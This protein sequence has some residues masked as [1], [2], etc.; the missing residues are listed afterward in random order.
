MDMIDREILH[1]VR[2]ILSSVS[3]NNTPLSPYACGEL[4]RLIVREQGDERKDTF[5]NG[6]SFSDRTVSDFYRTPGP[7]Q[8]L[9]YKKGGPV[10]SWQGHSVDDGTTYFVGDNGDLITMTQAASSADTPPKAYQNFWRC[11]HYPSAVDNYYDGVESRWRCAHGCHKS[12]LR[13]NDNGT[14]RAP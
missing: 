6:T 2:D 5:T 1:I 9:D 12:E 14:H 3:R 4:V 8:Q 13:W 10:P 11:E 7:W